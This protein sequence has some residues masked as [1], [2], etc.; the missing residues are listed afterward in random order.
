MPH[1][2]PVPKTNVSRV[3]MPNAPA[4]APA[5]PPPQLDQAA[6]QRFIELAQR[7]EEDEWD[8]DELPEELAFSEGDSD[9]DE[10]APVPPQLMNR[11]VARENINRWN[12]R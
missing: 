12:R 11:I 6:L 1:D 10:D 5:A 7:D 9:D 8:S 2:Q 3:G 4:Q